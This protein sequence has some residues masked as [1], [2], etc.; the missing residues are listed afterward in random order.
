M[1][2]VTQSAALLPHFDIR[3]PKGVAELGI[4]DCYL[5]GKPLDG[6][7]EPDHI[8]PKT[9]FEKHSPNRPTLPTHWRCN[10]DKSRED[11]WFRFV[12]AL[13]CSAS[14][15]AANSTFTQF[16]DRA[17]EQARESAYVIGA[18]RE[19]LREYLLARTILN[20]GPNSPL[21]FTQGGRPVPLIGLDD[22]N[23]QRLD[24]YMRR[25]CQGL[26]LRNVPGATVT[27]GEVYAVQY[28]HAQ[29]TGQNSEIPTTAMEFVRESLRVGSAF[30]QTWRPR[31]TYVGSPTEDPDVGFIYVELYAAA[32][33]LAFFGPE[34]NNSV[35]SPRADTGGGCPPSTGPGLQSVP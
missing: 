12:I 20:P 8:I 27:P 29:V 22:E 35:P 16:M 11:E 30:V 3:H 17:I 13:M 1:C 6:K 28:A 5:C 14:S 18:P 10:R 24:N 2:R 19:S 33:F 7:S 32:G 25:M 23:R 21:S 15:E 31:V 34:I 26:Y 9:V 4:V